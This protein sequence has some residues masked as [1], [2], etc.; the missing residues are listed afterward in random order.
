MPTP[1]FPASASSQSLATHQ[2]DPA[3]RRRLRWR[4]RRGLLENDLI[5]TR[6]LDRHETGLSDGEVAALDRLLDCQDNELLDLVL[7]RQEPE[8]ELATP[9]IVAV[10]GKIRAA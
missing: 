3:R 10:L 7:E 6:F 5:L 2:Q 9:D 1:D 8:G 4:A